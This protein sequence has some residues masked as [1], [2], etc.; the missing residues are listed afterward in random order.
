ML[1]ALVFPAWYSN[2]EDRAITEQKGH[3]EKAQLPE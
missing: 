1:F 2:R 3:F